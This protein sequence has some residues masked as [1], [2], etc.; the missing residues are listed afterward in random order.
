MDSDLI[1]RAADERQKIFDR[2]ELGR[3]APADPWEDPEMS[4]Y[5]LVD[6]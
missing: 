4:V 1:S 5:T 2:Y 3:K 6:R